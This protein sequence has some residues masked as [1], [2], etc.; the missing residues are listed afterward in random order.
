MKLSAL[1]DWLPPS[2]VRVLLPL[3]G[4]TIRYSGRYASYAEAAAH[5][6]GYAAAE[7]LH[8]VQAA[9]VAVLTGK[10]VAERD[11]VLLDRRLVPF[12]VVAELMFNAAQ[13]GGRLAV[14]DFGGSLGSV[15][16]A[17]TDY[18]DALPDVCWGVVE[19]E[20]FVAAGR[21]VLAN[22]RLRFYAGIDECVSEMQPH[23]LLLSSV[24][25]YLDEP[26]NFLNSVNAGAWTSI[27]IDRT[28][29][30]QA[31]PSFV[32][33]QS[34]PAQ[35]VK[36]SYPSWIISADEL[37]KALPD[38]VVIAEFPALDGRIGYGVLSADFRGM[39]LRRAPR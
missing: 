39:I 21:Q 26:M 14:C 20:M 5:T 24:L 33:V 38:Y 37:L 3:F 8:Q 22:E 6:T 11:G 16:R 4:K 1:K 27:I 34:V 30:V 10:S 7:I 32:T 25:Q 12:P 35:W 17:C 31:G 19:Q 18:L 2:L 23:T 13:A 9:T 29:F 15:Y 28:P 36:S